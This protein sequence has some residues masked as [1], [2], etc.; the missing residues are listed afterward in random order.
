MKMQFYKIRPQIGLAIQILWT[1]W[2]GRHCRRFAEVH[3]CFEVRSRYVEVFVMA[4]S[5]LHFDGRRRF[6]VDYCLT[7]LTRSSIGYSG[8]PLTD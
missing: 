6:I 5:K 7:F 3:W 2:D 8:V 1:Q 4:R